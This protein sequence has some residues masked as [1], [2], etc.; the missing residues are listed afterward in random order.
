MLT[1]F[2]NQGSAAGQGTTANLG[3]QAPNLLSSKTFVNDAGEI[4]Y[5]DPNNP[6]QLITTDQNKQ[7]ALRDPS[8]QNVNVYNRMPD[9]DEGRLSALG[10]LVQ[11][12]MGPNAMARPLTVAGPLAAREAAIQA[13]NR[14]GVDIPSGIVS[15]SPIGRFAGQVAA[16]APGGGPFQQAVTKSVGQLEGALGRVGEAAGGTTDK[17]V[18]GSN[19]R[20]GIKSFFK[21]FI[22]AR[23]EEAYGKVAELTDA[24]VKTPLTATEKAVEEISAKRAAYGDKNPGGAVKAVLNA[25][26]K[27]GS[28]ETRTI[29][30]GDGYHIAEEV[31]TRE[32]LNF[33]AI[34]DLR[35]RIGDMLDTGNLPEGVSQKELERVYAALSEDL[36]S[37]VHNSGGPEAVAAFKRANALAESIARHK[38]AIR[39]VLGGKMRADEGIADTILRMASTG[40]GADLDALSKARS[41]VPPE[42]WQGVASTAISKLGRNNKDEFSPTIFLSD[43][44]KLSDRGKALL[45]AS[46]GN[47][48]LIPFLDDIAG[49]SKTFHEA[50]KMA[51]VSG[52]GGHAALLGALYTAFGL[53][54]GGQPKAAA[55]I[56]GGLGATNLMARVLATKATAASMARW[57]RAYDLVVSNPTPNAIAVF[58]LTSRN[59]ANTVNSTLGTNIDP[60]DLTK[61]VQRPQ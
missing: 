10:H 56:V 53:V 33:N 45:F 6:G 5:E 16:R 13:G 1:D 12:G 42:V 9:T 51:N 41:A 25:V 46:V 7:V 58:N 8:T 59:F 39:K 24:K 15:T 20:Q 17:A 22:K 60:N 52:S 11:T 38:D 34:K 37:A 49:V 28:P 27:E 3:V 4:Q 36:K 54:M 23:Q 26:Y 14:I 61:A 47:R 19:F 35:T 48:D 43:Y 2:L 50:G 44:A 55:G 29:L 32:G 18:V 57:S 40:G 30:R 21:P 31:P